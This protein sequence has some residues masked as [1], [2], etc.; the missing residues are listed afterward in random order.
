MSGLLCSSSKQ[1]GP[2]LSVSEEPRGGTGVRVSVWD[3]FG[4][5]GGEK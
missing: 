3:G 1:T 2:S 4:M 5:G